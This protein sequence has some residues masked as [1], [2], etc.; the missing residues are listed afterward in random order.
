MSNKNDHT[1][2]DAADDVSSL[3]AKL[4][5]QG[6]NAYQD[7]S[8]VRLSAAE[9]AAV[10]PPPAVAAQTLPVARAPAE[11]SAVIAATPASSPLP[12]SAGKATPLAQV[13]RRLLDSGH[14]RTPL[15]DSPLK[16]FH[17]R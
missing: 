12:D 14:D 16:R 1:R 6:A 2:A 13:F 11:R 17:I 4:G 5:S 9:P 15:P 8:E 3:F 10:E 7:F